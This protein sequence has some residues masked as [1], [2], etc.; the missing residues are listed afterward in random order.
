MYLLVFIVFGKSLDMPNITQ[1]LAK[2]ETYIE[3]NYQIT[4]L[5]CISVKER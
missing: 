2:I 1:K 3:E 5:F 4:Y